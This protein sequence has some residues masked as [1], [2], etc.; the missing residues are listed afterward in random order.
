MASPQWNVAVPVIP[1]ALHADIRKMVMVH[2]QYVKWLT[3]SANAKHTD[4][5]DDIM[6]Q[7]DP[8][9]SVCGGSGYNFAERKVKMVIYE[10]LPHGFQGGAGSLH[11]TGGKVE[12]LDATAFVAGDV[13]KN[14]MKD[15]LIIFPFDASQPNT[16]FTVITKVP[17]HVFGNKPIVY[18]L[19]LFKSIRDEYTAN[20]RLF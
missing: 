8:D 11:T 10:E 3:K 2:G 6:E 18:K 20:P 16:E 9:C 17:F 13:G 1:R 4:C 7:P 19:M 14:I 12:R 5:W 15:D